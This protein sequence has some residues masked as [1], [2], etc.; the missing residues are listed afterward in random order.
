MTHVSEDEL[1]DVM[2]ELRTAGTP[3]VVATVIGARGSTPRKA[4][5]KMVVAGD[6]RSFGTVGGGAVE[7][8]VHER[9]R[10]V[11]ACPAVDRFTWELG[12]SEAG[13]MVCGGTMEF[14]LEP[15]GARPPAFVFGGGHVGKALSRALVELRFDVTVV[16]DREA[17]LTEE[18]LPGVRLV[19][20]AP[21]TAAAELALPPSAFAVVVTRG[22]AQ[23][24][25]TLRSLVRKDLRYL[26]LMGS[27]KKKIEIFD[28]LRA[29]G[30]SDEVLARVHCPVGLDIGAESPE[31]IAVA[32]AAEM[33]VTL[34]A[35]PALG[36]D[37]A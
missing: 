29:E 17:L 24:L 21:R 1:L 20:A 30:V 35:K 16:D 23:D 28:A 7:A 10:A 22:H 14:L 12:S 11:L 25:D 9:A 8:K 31:E 36:S 2:H 27:R 34:R 6:G 3:F 13:G 26:G 4:G 37:K 15:F 19:T 18:R 5:A 32:I 33:I